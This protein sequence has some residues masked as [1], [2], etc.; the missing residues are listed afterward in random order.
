MPY[1]GL[2]RDIVHQ[3][4]GGIR[5][6]MGLTGCLTVHHLQT[7]TSFVQVSQ[8][9]RAESHVHDVSMTKEPPNYRRGL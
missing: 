5:S 6:C 4:I 3:L 1:K 9:G 7:Q 8:A 2:L